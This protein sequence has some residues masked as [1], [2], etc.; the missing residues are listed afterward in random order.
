VFLLFMLGAVVVIAALFP[1]QF[2]LQAWQSGWSGLAQ[3]YRYTGTFDGPTWT[4][5]ANFRN[6]TSYDL[7]LKVGANADGL[8]LAQRWPVS[9]AHPPLL[10]AWR[11]VEIPEKRWT[12]W[13]SATML[14][15]PERFEMTLVGGITKEF[16]DHVLGLH[17]SARN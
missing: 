8:Y 15:G 4:W 9:V 14:L 6:L 5:T 3:Q 16:M 17:A 1:L 10:I 7:S 11:D 13:G 2:K 12:A